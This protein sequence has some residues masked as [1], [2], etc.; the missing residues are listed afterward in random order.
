M[1]SKGQPN[2]WPKNAENAENVWKIIKNTEKCNLVCRKPRPTGPK[3]Q[4]TMSGHGAAYVSR[5]G[6]NNVSAILDRPHIVVCT[7]SAAFSAFP[8]HKNMFFGTQEKVFLNF[9]MILLTFS[10][11]SAFWVRLVGRLSLSLPCSDNIYIYIHMNLWAARGSRTD[12][13]K[14]QKMPKTWES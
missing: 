13:P 1:S 7:T 11:F 12:D 3:L 5:L 8:G 14:N 9:F 2:R 6:T 10:A 4:I